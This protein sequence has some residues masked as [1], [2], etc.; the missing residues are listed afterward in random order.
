MKTP[1]EGKSVTGKRRTAS[2]GAR[3]LCCSGGSCAL[4]APLHT[5]LL[6]PAPLYLKSGMLHTLWDRSI[7]FSTSSDTV[8]RSLSPVPS[9]TAEV[10]PTV[11]PNGLI[12]IRDRKFMRDMLTARLLFHWWES[13][14]ASCSSFRLSNVS[15]RTARNRSD[16]SCTSGSLACRTSLNLAS[17]YLST[18]GPQHGAGTLQQSSSRPSRSAVLMLRWYSFS[19]SRCCLSA[20]F[21]CQLNSSIRVS[22]T[23]SAGSRRGLRNITLLVVHEEKSEDHVRQQVSVAVWRL[24]EQWINSAK[25]NHRVKV[26]ISERSGNLNNINGPPINEICGD[27]GKFTNCKKATVWTPLREKGNSLLCSPKQELKNESFS[28]L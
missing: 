21:S 17:P 7:P 14:C 19:R 27:E 6:L 2:C 26:W 9:A 24:K 16:T 4:N 25:V 10:R 20:S 8:L 1:G 11:L 12:L 18:T 22:V 28:W 15:R 5:T 23:T 13:R 3:W